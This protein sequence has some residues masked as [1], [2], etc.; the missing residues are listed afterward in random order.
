MSGT[1]APA[2]A[3]AEALRLCLEQGYVVGFSVSRVYCLHQ[4]AMQALDIPHS[5]TLARFLALPDLRRAYQARALSQHAW[6]VCMAWPRAPSEMLRLGCIYA[7][8][9]KVRGLG[10]R[11]GACLRRKIT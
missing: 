5:A 10:R 6:P 4:A 9:T 7:L 3:L 1:P 2:A 8:S 11:Q